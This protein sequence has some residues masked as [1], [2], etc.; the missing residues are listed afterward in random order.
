MTVSSP[1]NWRRWRLILGE[2]AD[3]RDSS[4]PA[5]AEALTDPH[6][7]EIDHFLSQI[8]D[9]DRAGGLALST[10]QL[11]DW[12]GDIRRYFPT[13]ISRLVQR[14]A[15]ERTDLRTVLADPRLFEVVEADVALLPEIIGLAATLPESTRQMAHEMV[16][17]IV[18]QTADRL[19]LPVEQAVQRHFARQPARRPRRAA[20]ID[21]PRTIRANLRHYQPDYQTIIPVRLHA[22]PARQLHHAPRNIT[23][24]VDL[25]RSMAGSTVHST[26]IAALLARIPALQTRLVAFDTSVVDLTSQ[27]A[28]PVD[29]LLGLNLGGGTDIRR[30][31]DYCRQLNSD[32]RDGVIFLISDLRD[33]SS[34]DTLLEGFRQLQSA[35]QR[36]VPILALSDEGGEIEPPPLVTSLATLGLAALVATPAQFPDLLAT[37]LDPAHQRRNDL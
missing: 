25:S 12:L 5:P 28:D 9:G 18:N 23:I 34:P 33:H 13:A 17:R 22:R 3:P 20:E 19:R 14:D 7:R 26:I 30:A 31:L 35:G 36:V 32:T 11:I 29:L 15:L 6:D 27:L 8:Y 21:W 10:P 4:R 16:R 37:A 24:C 1:D 2:T